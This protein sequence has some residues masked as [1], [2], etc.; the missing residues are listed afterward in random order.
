MLTRGLLHFAVPPAYAG[1]SDLALLKKNQLIHPHR[2]VIAGKKIAQTNIH[3]ER[4]SAVTK[5]M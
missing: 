5:L 2:I 4:Y 3:A 1:G